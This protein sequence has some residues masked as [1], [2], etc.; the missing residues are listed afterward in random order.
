MSVFLSH[1]RTEF[2]RRELRQSFGYIWQVTF[3][4]IFFNALYLWFIRM[5]SILLKSF[6]HSI[7]RIYFHLL[8][9]KIIALKK[10]WWNT[11][12]TI[13]QLLVEVRQLVFFS[14]LQELIFM[15]TEWLGSNGWKTNLT[16]SN[17]FFGFQAVGL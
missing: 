5:M 6:F 8:W 13:S 12:L 10:I 11:L 3:W 2:V 17:R 4:I 14:I 15:T 7:Y 1:K 16:V 9:N